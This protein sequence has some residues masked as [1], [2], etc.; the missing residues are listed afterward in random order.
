MTPISATHLLLLYRFNK[1]SSNNNLRPWIHSHLSYLW[2]RS[3]HEII[4]MESVLFTRFTLQ[5]LAHGIQA[6]HATIL[7]ISI[8]IFIISNRCKHNII[9]L[10]QYFLQAPDN[11]AQLESQSKQT[12][13]NNKNNNNKMPTI[14]TRCKAIKKLPNLL[15][16]CIISRIQME[17]LDNLLNNTKST[18]LFIFAKQRI[19]HQSVNSKIQWIY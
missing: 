19:Q 2:I 4:Q 10:D 9:N 5:S 17:E 14:E 16:S 15:R 8:I 1:N 11:W 18:D 3:N 7:S 13:N 6:P 12:N